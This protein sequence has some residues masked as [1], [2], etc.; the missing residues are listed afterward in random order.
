MRFLFSLSLFN[1]LFF[2]PPAN[3][4]FFL[5]QTLTVDCDNLPL[6]LLLSP[7]ISFHLSL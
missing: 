1:N 2:F 3:C 6:H 7:F 4:L 5:K